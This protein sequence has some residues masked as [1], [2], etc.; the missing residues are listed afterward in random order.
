[1]QRLKLILSLRVIILVVDAATKIELHKV[2]KPTVAKIQN[3]GEIAPKI[4]RAQARATKYARAG[5]PVDITNYADAQYY[6]K[7]QIGTP[8]QD[9]TVVFDTGSSNLW[10]PSA[11][12]SYL[13]IACWFHNRY[14]SSKSKTYVANGKDF[15]IQYGSG[16]LSGFLSQDT[17]TIGGLKVQKQIFAEAVNEPGLTFLVA[18]FDGI[19]GLAFQSISVDG[20]PPVWYNLVNQHLVQQQVFSFWLNRDESKKTGGELMLGGIDTT[21]YTGPITYVPLSNETYWE[22]QLG[23]ILVGGKSTGYCAKGCHAIADTGTSLIAGPSDMVKE[24]NKRIGAI[25]VISDECEMI[26]DQY[27]Q[28]IINAIVNDLNP[29]TVCT[30]IGLCPGTTCALCTTIISTLQQILPSNTSQTVIKVV[31]DEICNLLPSPMGESIV[32]C[33]TINTLPNLSFVL[34]GKSFVLTPQQYILQTGAAGQTMCLSG[35]IGLDLPPQV[36]PIWI[37][38]DVFIGAYYTVFDY[39]NSR[40][41]FATAK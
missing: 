2:K 15:E 9:F 28:E 18:Q 30:N 40:V 29:S 32:N 7:I 27:E 19:M 16:S 14:D 10:V 12:C 31:L 13:D 39:G 5:V 4:T 25:G 34:A 33:S 6:G 35:F 20:V 41:G 3:F 8:P 24:L 36:G 23:D 21:H 11:S 22:F 38:G 37:L 17:V 26:V 1:M